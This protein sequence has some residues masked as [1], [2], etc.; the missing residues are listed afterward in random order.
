MTLYH[1]VYHS[2]RVG[3]R[4]DVLG[5]IIAASQRNNA[6]LGVTGLL[7][8]DGDFYL[9]LLEGPRP[10][11]TRLLATI[12]NDPRHRDCELALFESTSVNLFAGWSMRLIDLTE[13]ERAHYSAHGL[14]LDDPSAMT[15]HA[16]WDLMVT[17]AEDY[18][19]FSQAVSGSGG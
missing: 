8:G 6:R 18:G 1:A 12:L 16:I 7:L 10:V 19:G 11:L 14:R 13:A 2:R 9:Q 17:I 3:A 5:Q 4:P 15:G